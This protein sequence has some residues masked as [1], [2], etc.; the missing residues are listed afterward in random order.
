MQFA[1]INNE[2]KIQIISLLPSSWSRNEIMEEFGVS[3]Y[4]IKLTRELVKEQGILPHLSKKKFR[5]V[6]DDVIKKVIEYYEDDVNS[7]LCPGKNSV[8]L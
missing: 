1:V 2:E 5:K 3:D 8:F 7:R 6:G 4:V